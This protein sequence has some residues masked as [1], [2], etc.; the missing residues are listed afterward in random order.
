MRMFLIVIGLLLI[1]TGGIWVLQGGGLL[2]GSFMSGQS[3]WLFIGL[4]AM[5]AG[6]VLLVV[7]A[8]PGRPRAGG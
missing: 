5:I 4:A 8:R 1:T 2:P 6:V 7:G 3:L